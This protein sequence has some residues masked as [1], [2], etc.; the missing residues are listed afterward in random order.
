MYNGDMKKCRVCKKE[1]DNGCFG[2]NGTQTRKDGSRYLR[3]ICRPCDAKRR[4]DEHA[5]DP[6]KIRESQRK[7]Y[8]KNEQYFRDKTS[9]WRK[10]NPEKTKQML[11]EW[12]SKN[13]NKIRN[14]ALKR[15]YGITLEDYLQMIKDQSGKCFICRIDTDKLVVDHDHKT[16]KVRKLLCNACN[17]FIGKIEKHIDKLDK[18]LDYLE[19]PRE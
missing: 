8:K 13:G 19:I 3:T 17:V 10:E 2:F 18:I 4:R 7:Y 6:K 15:N 5:N 11:K 14:Y 16:G 12:V 1:K 9:R